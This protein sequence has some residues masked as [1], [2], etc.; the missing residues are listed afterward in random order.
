[1]PQPTATA[2]A[3]PAS[4][5]TNSG[6]TSP[7]DDPMANRNRTVS[8]P[9]RATARKARPASAVVEP[10]ASAASTPRSSSPFIARPWRRIQNSIQVRTTTAAKAATPS[11]VARTIR[12]RLPTVSATA[13]PTPTDSARAAATPSAIARR[14]SA[15][16]DLTRYAAMMP[17]MSA[18]SRPSRSMRKNAAV[19]ASDGPQWIGADSLRPP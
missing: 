7:L 3:S 15:R 16:P 9:S 2:T 10:T 12:G 1:M 6:A 18:A 4:E 8:R 14:A 13:A 17:T 5:A 19:M 11:I